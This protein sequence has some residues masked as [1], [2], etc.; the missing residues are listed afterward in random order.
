MVVDFTR[1]MANEMPPWAT[2]RAM[3]ATTRDDAKDACSIDQVY[4]GLEAGIEGSINAINELWD[5]HAERE[6]EWG[7]LLVDAKI[8]FDE[9]NRTM[10]L[11][12]VCHKLLQTLG[13]TDELETRWDHSFP[14]Q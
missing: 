8:A 14:S 9:G 2:Y 11:W 3:L 12:T 10:I 1:W 4:A 6:D 13:D 7:F 5:D